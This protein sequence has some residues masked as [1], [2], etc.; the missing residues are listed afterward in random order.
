MELGFKEKKTSQHP[1]DQ[2]PT[3][4]IAIPPEGERGKK[5][6]NKE[7]S[8]LLPG[9]QVQLPQKLI[10]NPNTVLKEEESAGGVLFQGKK[11]AR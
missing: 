8:I 5:R 1:P 4:T 11:R 6:E 10:Q 7:A 2:L 3:G 9:W